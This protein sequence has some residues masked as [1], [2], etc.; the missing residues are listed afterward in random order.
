MLTGTIKVRECVRREKRWERVGGDGVVMVQA[1]RKL[2]DQA[3]LDM[4]P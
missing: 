2:G 3:E 1:K 4:G